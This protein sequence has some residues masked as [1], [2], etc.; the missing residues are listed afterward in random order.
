MQNGALRDTMVTTP[1][2]F[3]SF[4]F[5]FTAQFMKWLHLWLFKMLWPIMF[6]GALFT[7]LPL[8]G[9]SAW[10][11]LSDILWYCCDHVPNIVQHNTSLASRNVTLRVLKAP[12]V[13]ERSNLWVYVC[14]R[15]CQSSLMVMCWAKVYELMKLMK[16]HKNVV[17]FL[18]TLQKRKQKCWLVISMPH[19]TEIVPATINDQAFDVQSLL[20]IIICLPP[21]L[22]L[23]I[24]TVDSCGEIPHT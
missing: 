12:Q 16:R 6:L 21:F 9:L 14:D 7:P 19:W 17:N 15:L 13:M 8:Q 11:Q 20:H 23:S 10:G 3:I 5:S 2:L 1:G 18:M 4:L 22:S 24:F